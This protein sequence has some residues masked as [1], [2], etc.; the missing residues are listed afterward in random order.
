MFFKEKLIVCRKWE[1][2]KNM[3]VPPIKVLMLL[4]IQRSR[5]GIT[6]GTHVTYAKSLKEN[7]SRILIQIKIQKN[8]TWIK[9]FKRNKIKSEI[10][11]RKRNGFIIGNTNTRNNESY[12]ISWRKKII[13]GNIFTS[14]FENMQRQIAFHETLSKTYDVP[15]SSLVFQ[16]SKADI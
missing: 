7:S 4:S 5:L 10:Y 14:K 6:I 9:K 2:E 1:K 15:T 11:W 12:I 13:N 16:R 8:Y 3:N